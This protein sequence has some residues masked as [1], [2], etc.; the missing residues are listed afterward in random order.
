MEGGITIK[1]NGDS[2][3]MEVGD[4][5]KKGCERGMS[6]VSINKTITS[7]MDRYKQFFM[8]NQQDLIEST[9]EQ[10]KKNPSMVLLDEHRR[11]CE[12]CGAEE[13]YQPFETS[14]MKKHKP[15]AHH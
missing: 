8:E 15:M 5:L 6:Q 9:V 10:K 7:G 12:H 13:M 11:R 2:N 1:D 4:K 3:K 14:K